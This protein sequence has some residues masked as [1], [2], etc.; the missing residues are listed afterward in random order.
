MDK[1]K[2]S[3]QRYARMVLAMQER[4]M[5]SYYK[6]INAEIK[7]AGRTL[8]ALYKEGVTDFNDVQIEHGEKMFKILS[9]LNKQTINLTKKMGFIEIKKVTFESNIEEQIYNT[10]LANMAIT[11]QNIAQTTVA[12]AMAVIAASMEQN[13]LATTVQTETVLDITTGRTRSTRSPKQTQFLYPNDIAANITKNINNSS[14]SRSMTIARTETH[15]ATNTAQFMRA[16]QAANDSGIMVEVEWIATNDS[17]VRDAHQSADG[18]RV[19]MGQKFKVG[20]QMVRYPS[21]PE[22]S[23]ANSINCRCVLGYHVV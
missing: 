6:A 18:Q 19:P 10:L 13:V 5:L 20:G 21:A 11:A 14:L 9:G 8:A 7:R 17:R 22:C 15:K 12:S 1:A 23:A 3:R 4:I 16:E 2:L